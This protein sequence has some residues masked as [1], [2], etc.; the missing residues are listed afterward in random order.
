VPVKPASSQQVPVLITDANTIPQKPS[1]KVP[2]QR[3]PNLSV[4][5]GKALDLYKS[6]QYSKAI[7][8]FEKLLQQKAE[9]KL[10]DRYHFWMGVSYLN[11]NKSSQAIREFTRVLGYPHSEKLEEAYFM[12]GQCYER[13]GAKNSAKAAYEKMLQL[14]PHGNLKQVAE[15]KL[16]LLK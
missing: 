6:Q 4:N 2:V 13:T 1:P 12:I 14:F 3:S 11:L 10:A 7:E 9:Q 16:A 15:K 5:Y 8:V